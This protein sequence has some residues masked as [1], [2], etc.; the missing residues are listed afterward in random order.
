MVHQDSCRKRS[1][2]SRFE[3]IVS[4][5]HIQTNLE[6]AKFNII[7]TMRRLFD[8]PLQQP[9]C[10]VTKATRRCKREQMRVQ[11]FASAVAA[12]KAWRKKFALSA[13]LLRPLIK[14]AK[15]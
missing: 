2:V 9:F 11:H 7:A 8:H 6:W 13:Q 4:P 15:R 3:Q 14:G 12:L 1:N 10:A 5:L